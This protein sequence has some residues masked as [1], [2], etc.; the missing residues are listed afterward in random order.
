M[1]ARPHLDDRDPAEP[2]DW[3]PVS[4]EWARKQALDA[5]AAAVKAARDRRLHDRVT[6]GHADNATSEEQQ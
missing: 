5:T 2:R 4:H 1:T 6:A 3:Q